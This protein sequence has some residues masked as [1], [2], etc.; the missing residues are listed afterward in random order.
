MRRP[1]L[2]HAAFAALVVVIFAAPLRAQGPSTF[3]TSLL[4]RGL[5]DAKVGNWKAAAQELRIAAFGL[6]DDLPRYQTAHVYGAIASER[7]GQFDEARNAAEKVVMAERLSR[8]YTTLP[9]DPA[10]RS[11]FESLVAKYV[12]AERLAAAPAFA[13]I[14]STRPSATPRPPATATAA[15]LK[16]ATPPFAEGI[17]IA[18]RARNYW[19]AGDL[20]NAVKLATEAINLDFA[21]GPAR[22]VLGNIAA[23]ERR[24]TDVVEHFTI[25]R[26]TQRLT[27]DEKNKLATGLANVGRAADAGALRRTIIAAAAPTVTRPAPPP[28]PA[29]VPQPQPRAVTPQPQPQPQPQPIIIP[30]PAPPRPT[31]QPR[32]PPP[33]PVEPADARASMSRAPITSRTTATIPSTPPPTATKPLTRNTPPPPPSSGSAGVVRSGTATNAGANSPLVNAARHSPSE[34]ILASDPVLMLADAD[35]LLAQGKIIAARELFARVAHL[36]TLNRTTLLGAARGLNQTS[37]WRDSSASYQRAYPLEPGEELHMFHEAVNRYEMGDYPF[38]KELLRRAL[39][40]LPAS[41][42]LT[43]YK[44]K[45]EATP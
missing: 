15:P 27:E 20:V 38:A 1:N 13:H 10:T 21:S 37:A 3:Y 4:E 9:L 29:P 33:T 16:P 40:K 35:R 30:K 7:L 12:T 39:P 31:N 26:T 45:I 19:I 41:R 2:R 32:T 14:T 24:W 25:A 43:A 5:V 44:S 23:I 6:L 11:S 34:A 42:E 17:D 8:S 18:V 28:P 22:Q 36:Q